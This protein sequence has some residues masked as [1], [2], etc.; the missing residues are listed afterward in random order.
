MNLVENT[1]LFRS[2][3]FVQSIR[4]RSKSAVTKLVKAY[5]EQLLRASYGLGFKGDGAAELV[6]DVWITFI[7]VVPRFEGR[8]H[9][10]TFLFGILYR[11]ACE[12]RR[13]DSRFITH[14]PID[15]SMDQL[16]DKSGHWRKE[17]DTPEKFFL[18]AQTMSIIRKCMDCLPLQQKAA[19]S[20]KEIEEL[21]SQEICKILSVSRTNLGVL[22][23]RARNRLRDC[24]TRHTDEVI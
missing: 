6:Q 9:V 15:E 8:S 24:I 11:K 18:A 12:K 10:R 19:F 13:E 1:E 5:S 22:L 4:N 7:E 16:F 23:F 2:E 21:K 14:D 3:D 17:V 20:L